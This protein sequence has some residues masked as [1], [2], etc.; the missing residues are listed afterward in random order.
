MKNKSMSYI[1][2][3]L[4]SWFA[5][6]CALIAISTVSINLIKQESRYP[7]IE[8]EIMETFFGQLSQRYSIRLDTNERTWYRCYSEK[9]FAILQEKAVVGKRAVIWYN[10]D[11]RIR[12]LIVEGEIII[13]FRRG[14]GASIFLICMGILAAI[15]SVARIIEGIT[16]LEGKEMNKT[17]K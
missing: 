3:Y 13:P 9:Y 2:P 5:L 16:R 6:C 15:V 12:K 11:R 10:K 17:E 8:G 4:V 7:K 1:F 14:I